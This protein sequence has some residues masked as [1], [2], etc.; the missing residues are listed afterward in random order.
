MSIATIIVLSKPFSFQG[1]VKVVGE[2]LLFWGLG[3]FVC[4]N[5]FMLDLGQISRVWEGGVCLCAQ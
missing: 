2:V 3:D 4:F 1:L 5:C